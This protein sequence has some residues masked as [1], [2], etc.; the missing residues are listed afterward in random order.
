MSNALQI[1]NMVTVA[2]F[3]LFFC[4]NE[5][6]SLSWWVDLVDL[7]LTVGCITTWS[8]NDVFGTLNPWQVA[9]VVAL[10]LWR[11]VR[12]W[13]FVVLPGDV[14]SRAAKHI[15]IAQGKTSFLEGF[16]FVFISRDPAFIELFWE[17][18]D[19]EWVQLNAAW[20]HYASR[21]ASIEVYCTSKDKLAVKSLKRTVQSTSLGRA[22]ALHFGRPDLNK[23]AQ[24][25]LF[26]NILKDNM[27][28]EG[29]P[30]F[31][32]TLFAFCGGTQLG[33]SLQ[34]STV[35]T[36]ALAKL[37]QGRSIHHIEF[38]QENY[39]QDTPPKGI[40][41][42]RGRRL[43]AEWSRHSRSLRRLSQASEDGLR[44]MISQE[45]EL[46]RHSFRRRSYALEVEECDIDRPIQLQSDLVVR[47]PSSEPSSTVEGP[48]LEV[49]YA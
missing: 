13:L 15:H 8:Y 32:S 16:K 1:G 27:L 5:I 17:E 29:K 3:F 21:V 48:V 40:D 26:T 12:V 36:N 23:M 41:T 33:N 49:G 9:A 45:R 46:S 37:V 18:L 7:V 19:R 44:V 11:M 25:V 39:G 20:G 4:S 6:A 35:T 34:E 22:G 38:E 28:G 2:L 24:D 14:M 30:S 10:S 31:T 43:S 42:L 47:I